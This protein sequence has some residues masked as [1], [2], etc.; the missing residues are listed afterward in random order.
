MIDRS[1][2]LKGLSQLY[3]TQYKVSPEGYL[4]FFPIENKDALEE[5][6]KSMGMGTM[7][8]YKTYIKKGLTK[9]TF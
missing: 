2:I 3:G 6:R 7:N 8:E 4:D 5:R 1:R 9:K